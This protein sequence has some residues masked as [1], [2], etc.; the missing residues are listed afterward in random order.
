MLIVSAKWTFHL[1]TMPFSRKFSA[2][3]AIAMYFVV[4]ILNFYWFLLILKGLKRL[5]QEQGILAKND[6]EKED[7]RL[8]FGLEDGKEAKV[9]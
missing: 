4:I 7:E 1:E 2:S 6:N 5:L 9:Q 3:L 8:N